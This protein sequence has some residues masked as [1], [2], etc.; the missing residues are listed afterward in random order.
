MTTVTNVREN[1]GNILAD[2]KELNEKR[3]EEAA[4]EVVEDS[5]ETAEAEE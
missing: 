5:A 3:V 2:A 4:P 1:A